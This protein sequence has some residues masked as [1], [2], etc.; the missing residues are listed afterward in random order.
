V[1]AVM[2]L[3][4]SILPN[5]LIFGVK[6]LSRKSIQGSLT[7]TACTGTLVHHKRDETKRK[8]IVK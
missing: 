6:H 8:S 4:F 2:I 3:W 1:M 7:S 5:C